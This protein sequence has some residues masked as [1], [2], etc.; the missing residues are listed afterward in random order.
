MKHL[1]DIK[2]E[3]PHLNRVSDLDHWHEENQTL[4]TKSLQAF[5]SSRH[6]YT[7]IR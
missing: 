4:A 3:R 7:G 6:G 5:M 1:L 2:Q